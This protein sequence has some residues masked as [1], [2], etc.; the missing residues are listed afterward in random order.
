MKMISVNS[1]QLQF[2]QCRHKEEGNN[3]QY[4]NYVKDSCGSKTSVAKVPPYH[5]SECIM[6]LPKSSAEQESV[7]LLQQTLNFK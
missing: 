4:K 1:D 5:H 3:L 6:F 7:V 2:V